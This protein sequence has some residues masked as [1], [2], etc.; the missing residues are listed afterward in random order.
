MCY[1]GSRDVEHLCRGHSGEKE[2]AFG[3]WEYVMVKLKVCLLSSEHQRNELSDLLT[4]LPDNFD[5]LS[6]EN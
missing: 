6:G 5:S 1:L 3:V 2:S 4:A